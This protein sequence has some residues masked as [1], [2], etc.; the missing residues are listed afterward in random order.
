LQLGSR[1]VGSVYQLQRAHLE[2]G[3]PSHWTPYVR[4]DDVDAA[5]S[6]TEALGGEVMIAPVV[7]A[8]MARI[9]IIVDPVGAHLGLWQPLRH[10]GRRNGHG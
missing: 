2:R 4:V 5:T 10:R 8:D 1:Q 7:V 3:V 6:Q 9:S